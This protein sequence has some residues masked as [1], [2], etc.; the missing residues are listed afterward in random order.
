MDAVKHNSH[1]AINTD[2]T[3]SCETRTAS[4]KGWKIDF[5]SAHREKLTSEV[6]GMD[7][8]VFILQTHFTQ[9]PRKH[10]PDGATTD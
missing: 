10:S 6:F 5:Y 8:T 3:V 9:S 7:H 4:L 1:N 2:V